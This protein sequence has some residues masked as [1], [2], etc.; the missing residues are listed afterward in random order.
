MTAETITATATLRIEGEMDIYRAAE[1]KNTLLAALDQT[2]QL[3]L[4]LAS[5]SE[6]DTAGVQV[7]IMIKKQALANGR[8]LRLIAHS[9]A[10]IEVLKL[11]NLIT[12]F[13]DSPLISASPATGRR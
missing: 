8:T 10:V 3:E 12:Y 5:V 6:L 11:F 9:R 2:K 7:L 1:L 4:D 13:D